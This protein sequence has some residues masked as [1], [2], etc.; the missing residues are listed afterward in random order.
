MFSSNVS[1]FCWNMTAWR[2]NVTFQR[3]QLKNALHNGCNA[4]SFSHCV[5]FSEYEQEM[6]KREKSPTKRR[7]S[8]PQHGARHLRS[9]AG[10]L[11]RAVRR[12]CVLGGASSATSL[13]LLRAWSSGT[14]QSER[15]TGGR[16][17]RTEAVRPLQH[18]CTTY[19]G[20][21]TARLSLDVAASLLTVVAQYY[22]PALSSWAGRRRSSS[23]VR[24]YVYLLLHS[25]K[26]S[27]GG[28]QAMQ[29]TVPLPAAATGCRAQRSE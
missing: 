16:E 22:Q 1:F 10:R 8:R 7:H 2:Q 25:S 23:Y 3:Y 14:R 26:S 5:P 20:F 28:R 9:R 11:V 6:G 18:H 13:A 15:P 12:R 24:T 4:E 21:G 29:R 17:G 19:Y 27:N